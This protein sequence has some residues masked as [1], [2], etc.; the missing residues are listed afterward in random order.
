LRFGHLLDQS[1]SAHQRRPSE[2]VMSLRTRCSKLLFR[3]FSTAMVCAGVFIPCA[4]ADAQTTLV[5]SLVGGSTDG[6][7]PQ[8]GELI[9]A[10]D[11]N[12]YGTTMRGGDRD[13]GTVFRLT[14]AGTVS[15][16]HSFNTFADGSS[17]NR[18][19][20]L[21]AKDGNFY[22]TTLFGGTNQAGTIFRMTADG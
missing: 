8:G 14:P 20:L 13:E 3:G 4:I 21:Q 16:L 9:R 18:A 11:G 19:G 7:S 10:I 15:V 22:G 6:A 12:F 17:P 1:R 2:R 5:H